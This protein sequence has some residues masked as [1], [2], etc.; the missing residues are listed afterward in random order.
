LFQQCQ[1]RLK[2]TT[3]H[4]ESAG[5]AAREANASHRST[6]AATDRCRPAQVDTHC[7]SEPAPGIE[8]RPADDCQHRTAGPCGDLPPACRH[9]LR[10]VEATTH[11]S[12]TSDPTGPHGPAC[13]ATLDQQAMSRQQNQRAT[14][15][16]CRAAKVYCL[17]GRRQP[18]TTMCLL[19]HLHGS[20]M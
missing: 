11:Q 18:D 12:S 19:P 10:S 16:S 2:A 13:P 1:V 15:V 14:S 9:P 4:P 6:T 20:P 5:L 17:V 7:N 8:P 3:R